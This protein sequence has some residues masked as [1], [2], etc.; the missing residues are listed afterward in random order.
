MN[1]ETA[2]LW[3]IYIHIN[4]LSLQTIAIDKLVKLF[5]TNLKR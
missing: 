5:D 3:L 2:N 4:V 1:F